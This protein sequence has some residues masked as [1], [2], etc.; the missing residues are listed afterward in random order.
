M[1]NVMV[2]A[3]AIAKEAVNKFG[4]K[5][6]EYFAQALAM[7]WAESKKVS[8][9]VSI[10]ITG[11]SRKCRTWVAQI[12]GKHPKFVLDRKF[13]TPD[14]FDQYDDKVFWVNDGAYELYD[15]K[16][17]YFLIIENGEYTRTEQRDRIAAMFN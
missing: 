4:G 17:R 10:E 6:K 15:G 16:R 3:W 8:R 1:K 5:V 2:R 9:K 11:D 13:L 14:E 12:V 7:A